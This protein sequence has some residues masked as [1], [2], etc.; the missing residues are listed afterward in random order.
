[1][2][3]ESKQSYSKEIDIYRRGFK[4]NTGK[5]NRPKK[6]KHV[7]GKKNRVILA[8]FPGHIYI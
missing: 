2:A 3:E 1:M 7:K 6:R 8:G 4:D 5:Q